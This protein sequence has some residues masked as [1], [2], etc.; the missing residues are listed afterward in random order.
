MKI[1][2]LYI[3]HFFYG[4]IKIVK[5]DQGISR[6]IK[7]GATIW[8]L[9]LL[10]KISPYINPEKS[11]IDAGANMGL[12]SIAFAKSIYDDQKVYAF[13]CHPEIYPCLEYNSNF[14]IIP[15]SSGLSS[16]NHTAYV[17]SIYTHGFEN[18]ADIKVTDDS[19]L[20]YPVKLKTI[21]SYEYDNIGF[22]KIDTEWHE[23]FVIDG[24]IDTI[25]KNR[26]NMVIEIMG[27]HNIETAPKDIVDKIN[28]TI[29]KV[30]DLGY[31]HQQIS[32]HDFLFL[33]V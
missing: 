3:D 15:S 4:T 25:N 13:E 12:H 21:D 29:Q 27:G 31:T 20:E 6:W 7:D 1:E 30:C 8:E 24:A 11:V 28:H 17:P 26:P 14:K 9:K 33:P 18:T 32:Y 16:H 22:I 19:S 23:D 2:Y 10:E 5:D